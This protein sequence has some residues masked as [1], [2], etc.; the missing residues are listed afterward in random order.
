MPSEAANQPE[1]LDL[2]EYRLEWLR[3]GQRRFA[4]YVV[5]H[6]SLEIAVERLFLQY[7]GAG[8]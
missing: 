5:N 2:D 6:M 3:I 1:P 8:E 7:K 4:M